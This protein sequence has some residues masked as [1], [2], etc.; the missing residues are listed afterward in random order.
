MISSGW[1]ARLLRCARR[2]A[3]SSALTRAQKRAQANQ[4]VRDGVA[5]KQGRRDP[6]EALIKNHSISTDTVRWRLLKLGVY[7]TPRPWNAR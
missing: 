7:R 1:K 2:W 5:R 4:L 3:R 6:L